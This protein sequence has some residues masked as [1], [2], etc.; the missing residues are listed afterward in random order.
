[1]KIEKRKLIIF[2]IGF[3][4]IY[5]ILSFILLKTIATPI[6]SLW[7]YIIKGIFK[8]YFNYEPFIFVPICSGVISISVYLGIIIS[9]KIAKIKKI[10]I[11]WVL[12]SVLLIWLAN[13]LRIILV[14]WSEKLGL[15]FT[16][17]THNLS[18]FLVGAVILYLALKTFK[19]EK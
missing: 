12:L 14:L 16:K 4:L 15:V 3:I 2:L 8:D 5:F 13:F 7:E 19:K 1:M 18:W 11:K 10:E 6:V 9:S 17:I